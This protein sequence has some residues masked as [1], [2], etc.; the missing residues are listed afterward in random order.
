MIG[1][2]FVKTWNALAALRAILGVF[3]AALFPGA[4]YLIS[5]WYPRRSMATRNT[6][7]YLASS[8]IGACSAPLGYSFTLMHGISGLSGW[9]WAFIWY[10]IITV[11][12]GI[13]AYFTL[14]DFPDRATFLTEEQKKFIL[15]RIER[16]RGDSTHDPVTLKKV[17]KYARDWK[18]WLYALMFCSATVASYSLA[19]F[20]PMIL[21]SMGFN[22]VETIV[23]GA[24][25]QV[26]SL[27]PGLLTA[28]V[29]DK[30]KNMRAVVIVFN[31]LCLIIGTCMYSQL[32]LKMKAARFAGMFLAG[33]GCNSNVPLVLSWAQ[34]SIR[35]QSKRAFTAAI[36]VAFG[37]VGG[38]L[39][40]V[41]FMQKEAPSY[42]TGVFFTIGINAFT[43]CACGFLHGYYRWQNRRADKGLVVLEDSPGFR[44]QG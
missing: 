28:Y 3:E 41:V 40:G 33:G 26:W 23:L 7:F 12:V 13:V 2:G 18:I 35:A 4:A 30:Y 39:S 1:M 17:I 11:V 8:V 15:T 34:C 32:P 43:I 21:M 27:V 37:G 6:A 36:I 29:A 22:N 20:G 25:A 38:I 44:Y 5:C 31:C 19:Y 10:G 42:R 16:D 24:P 9:S 14:V